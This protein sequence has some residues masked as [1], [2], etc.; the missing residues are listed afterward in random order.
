MASPC[1]CVCVCVCAQLCLW[2]IFG[3]FVAGG[4][5]QQLTGVLDALEYVV[6]KEGRGGCHEDS[7]LVGRAAVRVS[8]NLT[9]LAQACELRCRSGCMHGIMIGALDRPE[10][11]HVEHLNS[12]SPL[13]IVSARCHH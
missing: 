8:L 9:E 3:I 7:H 1:V 2:R 6:E 5:E 4:R 11:A 10:I 13:S 12:S